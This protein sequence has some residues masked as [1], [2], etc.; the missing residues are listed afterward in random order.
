MT[1]GRRG[2]QMILTTIDI[3]RNVV[4]SSV[5]DLLHDDDPI[6]HLSQ[7]FV[8]EHAVAFWT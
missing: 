6:S 8:C 4:G 3:V 1:S 5:S 2:L 7:D